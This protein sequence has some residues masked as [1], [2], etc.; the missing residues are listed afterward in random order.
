MLENETQWKNDYICQAGF[1]QV[2]LSGSH[3]DASLDSLWP[4]RS[5]LQKI[6]FAFIN[7]KEYQLLLL[8][9]FFT[10]QVPRASEVV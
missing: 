6:T 7:F 9:F 8:V 4:T 5:I 10:I 1:Q 2:V 3:D